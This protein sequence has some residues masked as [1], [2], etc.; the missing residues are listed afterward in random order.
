MFRK[1]VSL[2]NYTTFKIGGKAKYFYIT[3][4]KKDLTDAASMAK[5]L[6][7]PFFVLG[8]GS[9]LLVS[10]KGF[11]GLV[12]KIE[13]CKLKIEKYKM[14]AE[15]GVP[16]GQLVSAATNVGLSGMEWAAGI[17][18]TVGGAVYGNAGAF[19]KSMKDVVEK[20]EVFDTKDL[21][22]KIYNSRD[23][24]FSYRESIFK[25]RKNLIIV[26]S[27]LKLKKGEKFEIKKR[28]KEYVDYKIET[29]PLNYPSAG[30]VFKNPTK[31]FAAKLIEKCGLKGKKVN[32]AKISEKHANFIVNL[33]KA[34]EKDIKKLINLIKKEVKN[35]FGVV[36]EEE[37]QFL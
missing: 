26:S 28:I 3:Q 23:C 34:N 2:K 33:G 30:S 16:L 32:D 15:A 6:K 22:F 10:D 12:I 36:L 7:L 9:N 35:K 20:V 13:N 14:V 5:K 8:G 4:T 1:N 24:K 18:G 29:Q 37:I 19:R 31:D 11:D 25:K 27:I 17:P 21:E